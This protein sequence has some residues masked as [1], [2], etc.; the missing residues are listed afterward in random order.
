MVPY[1]VPWARAR[2]PEPSAGVGVWKSLASE[3]GLFQVPPAS[4][5]RWG[6][7]VREMLWWGH[8]HGDRVT[9]VL[10]GKGTCLMWGAPSTVL[11]ADIGAISP[12]SLIPLQARVGIQ[13]YPERGWEQLPG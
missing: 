2:Q 6:G 5:V 11:L 7:L 12:L 4:I 3:L 8:L 1:L 13:L 10:Q 9:C